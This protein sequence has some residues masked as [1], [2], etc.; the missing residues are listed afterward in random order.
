[1]RYTFLFLVLFPLVTHGQTLKPDTLKYCVN[2]TSIGV[3]GFDVVSYFSGDTPV[4]GDVKYFAV[5]ERVRYLFSSEINRNKFSSAPQEYLPQF[6]GWCSMTLVLGKAT[7]P[8][9]E[10][11]L[12][13]S[14]K[15][16]L[17]E[18]TLSVNG[19]ELWLKDVERN[20]ALASK[21][22][23]QYIVSGSIK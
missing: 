13:T 5:Y 1:M 23:R 4:K 12:I 18:R 21:N 2:A 16:Y 20:T 9:F 22:Y 15:L 19:K 6:G 11:F 10:N 3:G 14:G 7:T 8:T 17:F